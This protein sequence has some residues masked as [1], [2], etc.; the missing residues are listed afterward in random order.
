MALV[1]EYADW[2][3]VPMHQTDRLESAR[4]R[5]GKARLS[6]QLLITLVADLAR[7]DEVVA[8]AQR[9][10]GAMSPAGHL[11]GTADEIMPR[12]RDL[13]ERGVERIYTWFTDFAAPETLATFGRE[14]IAAVG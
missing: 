8:L 6:V 14:V 3:N 9:R 11:I 2:W 4:P 5:A 10:F 1:A 12:L 7:R 13:A